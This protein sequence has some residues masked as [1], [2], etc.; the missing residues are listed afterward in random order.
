MSVRVRLLVVPAALALLSVS[1]SAQAQPPP[2]RDNAAHPSGLPWNSGVF[3]QHSGT[4]AAAFGTWRN[5]RPV[6]NVVVFPTRDNWSEML[7]PWWRDALPPGFDPGTQDLVLGVPLWPENGKVS[8]NYDSQWATL[9]DQV[10]ATDSNAYLRLGW[11][12]NIEQYWKVTASNRSAWI[13]AFKRAADVFE[14]RCPDCRIVFNPNRGADQTGTDSRSVFQAVKSKVDVYAIDAY[15]QW[16]PDTSQAVW[17]KS[18]L[19]GA[20]NLQDSYDYA[21]ANSKLFAV[22]EWGLGCTTDG[23]QWEGHAGGDNPRYLTDYLDWFS[24]VRSGLA[25]ESYFNEPDDYIRSHLY[26]ADTNPKAAAAYRSKIAQY[27]AA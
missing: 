8:A 15:D 16:P 3:A 2:T 9:A 18:H 14:S 25:F 5:G 7:N 6:D 21:L 1:V 27:D 10:N 23:C 26:P 22:P 24:S 4:K 11:E 13:A 20:R 19:G 17:E 12:M